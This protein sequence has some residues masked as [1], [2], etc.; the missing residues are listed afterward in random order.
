[1]RRGRGG[2]GGGG[3]G[4]GNERAEAST[5]RWRGQRDRVRRRKGEVFILFGKDFGV[6]FG[7]G[8]EAGRFLLGSEVACFWGMCHHIFCLYEIYCHH[9]YSC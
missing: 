5:R 8:F 2:G 9:I 1:V 3:G 4:G 6:R 7:E